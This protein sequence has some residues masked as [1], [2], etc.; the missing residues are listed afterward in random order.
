MVLLLARLLHRPRKCHEVLAGLQ[1]AAIERDGAIITVHCHV[2]APPLVW[3]TAF[4][5]P[6]QSI[7]EWKQGKGFEVCASGGGRVAIES[8]AISG[9][10]VIIACASDPGP[11]ARV[12]YAMIGERPRMAAPFGGTFRW[13]LLRDSDPFQGA[14]TKQ[15]QPNYAVAFEMTV[16]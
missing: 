3:E 11:N 7:N 15:A 1:P 5:A 8:V 2:P 4:Q 14:V 9:D 12:G 16:P 13:G 10:S 6:H